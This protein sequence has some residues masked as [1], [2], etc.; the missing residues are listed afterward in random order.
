MVDETLPRRGF[1][2]GA[3]A[4]GTAVATALA[5]L[6]AP[7]EAQSAKPAKA[8]PAAPPPEPLLTLTATEAA[9]IA[10]AVDTFI[11]ADEL[12]PAGSDCGVGTFIDRQLAGA[13]GSGA[14]LYR[15]GPFFNGKPEH[16]YQLAL[17]P[18]EFFRAGIAAA[19]DWTRKIYGRE[20]DRLSATDREA[21]LKLLEEGKVEFPGFSSREFFEALLNITMEG[22]FADPIYGGNRDKVA[23]KMIGYPG[24][25]YDYRD[26]VERHNQ[27]YPLPPVGIS[28]RPEW[29]RKSG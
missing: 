21:A 1:L 20:F 10:A 14:R 19:N 2:K 5:G 17:T 22:F 6:P 7:A 12:T 23:W 4:A 29:I 27:R 25:R 26:W 15:D 11:P 24:A 16:G 9:F 28:G 8:K 13:W 3:G 18:R